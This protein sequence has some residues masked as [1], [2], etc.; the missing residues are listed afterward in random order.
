VNQLQLYQLAALTGDTG[1]LAAARAK[2]A[3]WFLP[4]V[5]S[6][7]EMPLAVGGS[8]DGRHYIPPNTSVDVVANSNA[9]QT[10]VRNHLTAGLVAGGVVG[11][12][13]GFVFRRR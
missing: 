5:T 10:A 3:Q 7:A 6:V 12:L 9:L 8:A 1:D 4:T 11:L 13:L 2:M